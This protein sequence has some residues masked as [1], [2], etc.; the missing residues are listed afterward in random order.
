MKT[1]TKAL[2]ALLIWL[3][4]PLLF[5]ALLAVVIVCLNGFQMAPGFL[6]RLFM[7]LG[8]AG[9]AASGRYLIWAQAFSDS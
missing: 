5:C 8:L 9:M 6:N 4:Y 3:I 2:E 1:L 7:I